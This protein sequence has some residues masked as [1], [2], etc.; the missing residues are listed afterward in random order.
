MKSFV[1]VLLWPNCPETHQFQEKVVNVLH[2][3][4][5]IGIHEIYVK[6]SEYS[7]LYCMLYS[8]ASNSFLSAR[9]AIMN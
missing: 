2:R 4:R 9:V 5:K 6:H 7:S 3:K 8:V 1:M